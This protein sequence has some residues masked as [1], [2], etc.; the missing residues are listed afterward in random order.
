MAEETYLLV[1]PHTHWDREWYQTFQQ[2]RMRLVRAVDKVLDVLERDPTFRYFMLDGQTIVLEDYLAIRPENELR[3]RAL[4][5]QGRILVG[6]WYL[7]PDEF[8]VGG[9]SLIRNLQIGRRMAAPYGGAMSVGYVPDTFGHIAQ[10]PQ[11]LRGFDIDNAVFWRG[12]PPLVDKGLF[13]W[14]APDGSAVRVIWLYDEFGY[15]NA[16]MLPPNAEAL[17]ARVT[18]IAERMRDKA[19]GNVYLLMNGSDHLEPQA[20]LPAILDKANARLAESNTRLILGTLPQYVAKMREASGPLPT[21]HGE[22]RSSY[23]AHLLPGVLSTRMWLKQ[24]NAACEALL[25]RWAEPAA[26]WAWLFGSD[27][28]HTLL[29]LSWQYLLQN[30]PHDSICGCGIDQ[31]HAEMLPRFDQSEQIAEEVTARALDS[32]AGHAS[33]CAFDRA[34]PIVV[35]N[36]G[37]GTRTDAVQVEAQIRSSD[38]EVVDAQGRVLPHQTLSAHAGQL[39]D[40]EVDKSLV[41]AGLSMASEGRAFGFTLVDAWLGMDT[42]RPNTALVDVVVSDRGD[43]DPAVLERAKAQAAALAMRDD[44]TSF[45]V[46]AREAK[47][48]DVL[49]L[50]RD[51]PAHGGRVVYLRPR[52]ARQDQLNHAGGVQIGPA[53]IENAHLRV[54]VD[55][56]D[57]TL[58]LLDRRTGATYAGLNAIADTGDVGDLYNYCPPA[59]DTL[60]TQPAWPPSIEVVEAGP[61]RASLR[62]TRTYLLPASCTEARDARSGDTVRCVVTSDVSLTINSRRAEIRTT[63]ENA[64]RDHRLRVLF[65][66]PFVAETADAEGVF[67]VTTRPA[68][69]TGPEPGEPAWLLWMETPVNTHPQKR[70]VDISDGTR[71][72]AI[73]NRG[74]PEYEVLPYED[75]ESSAIALTLLRCVEWLSRDDLATRRNHAG[76]ALH[77]P[78]AQG[79]GTYVFEYALVPHP[80][81]WRAEDAT[82]LR[83]AQ[84][85]EAG[86]RAS[87]TERHDGPLGSSWSFVHVTPATVSLSAVKH[88]ADADALIVRLHNPL[89]T[90]VTSEVILALP[91][92]DVSVVNLNED[93]R[94][95]EAR[96]LA[97]ILSTGVRTV[98]RG[99]EIKTLKFVL[100]RPAMTA[101]VERV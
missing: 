56:K 78:A 91:F 100:D 33:T 86:L 79:L 6:P 97:R 75:G 84:A 2:F 4:I 36:P 42:T 43:P 23:S 1:V 34:V 96:E 20:E 30:H 8:L 21:L 52:S 83:E 39:M 69:R 76:P 61:V 41:L 74:L 70:F 35:F 19:V 47:K 24:R 13:T 37:A 57:G 45:R 17:A 51:V 101:T 94:P 10:L 29:D 59:S 38:F 26:A 82:V 99:G 81:T 93:E 46:I 54:D 85:F 71:G 62:V 80:G 64:A 22:M 92:R 44:I 88:A 27:Y 73:L 68:Q 25:T 11:I 12:V 72:L 28:P 53:H 9:E 67:D 58:T 55:A 49:L 98:L 87:V 95:D 5:S 60:V 18:Q 89:P 7:Q 16:A 50:A 15:S 77:T 65:P 66:V 90:P 3:L 32:L 63:V 48:T 40:Q 14:T 31:V